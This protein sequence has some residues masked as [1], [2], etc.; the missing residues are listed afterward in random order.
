VTAIVGWFRDRFNAIAEAAVVGTVG[1]VAFAASASHV[2][3]VGHDHQVTGWHSWSVA[4]TVEILAAYA[5][6]ECRRW[7]GWS[8]ILPGLIFVQTAAFLVLANLASQPGTWAAELLPWG[9]V[10]AAVPPIAF[11]EVALIVETKHWGKA[12]RTA[13]KMAPKVTPAKPQAKP[14]K[15]PPVAPPRK[16]PEVSAPKVPLRAVGAGSDTTAEPSVTPVR[17]QGEDRAQTVSR[18]LAEG[19]R[20]SV[21]VSAGAEAFGVSVRSM[22]RIIR[23]ARGDAEAVS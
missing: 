3:D 17:Y 20:Y 16:A 2:L 10:Y 21:M 8:R 23:D 22:K 15:P 11:L 18:W 7:S 14:Q 9:Q 6:L 1:V 13:R 4:G 5:A 12:A 19:H